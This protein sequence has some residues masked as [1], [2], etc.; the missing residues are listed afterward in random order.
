MLGYAIYLDADLL[1]Q[2]VKYKSNIMIITIYECIIY[3]NM[4]Y[5]E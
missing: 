3:N 2:I 1:S 5:T 4:Y